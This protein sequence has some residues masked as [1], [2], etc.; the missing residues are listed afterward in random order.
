MAKKKKSKSRKKSNSNNMFS[1]DFGDMGDMMNAGIGNPFGNNK[2]S[3]SN[4]MGFGM[5]NMPDIGI[6]TIENDSMSNVAPTDDFGGM[7][8]FSEVGF[9]DP[10]EMSYGN[11]Q[12][13]SIDLGMGMGG[14]NMA[15]A[16]GNKKQKPMAQNVKQYSHRGKK[17]VEDPENEGSLIPLTTYKKRY[18]NS[19]QP[20]KQRRNQSGRQTDY[21]FGSDMGGDM[22]QAFGEMKETYQVGKKIAKTVRQKLKN[23]E[24]DMM[25]IETQPDAPQNMRYEKESAVRY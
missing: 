10:P 20:K 21:S 2:K 11:R 22:G 17:M 18:G 6:P 1:N 25:G 8:D 23:P 15:D 24:V 5:G 7:G 9:D 4:D 13:N 16:F 14:M 3:K 12:D 19:T